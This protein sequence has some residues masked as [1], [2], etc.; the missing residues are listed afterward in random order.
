MRDVM[1]VCC[2]KCRAVM[3]G[4]SLPQIMRCTTCGFWTCFGRRR[5]SFSSKHTNYDLLQKQKQKC[6]KRREEWIN[7][8]KHDGWLET[9]STFN[10]QES[11]WAKRMKWKK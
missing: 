4:V 10:R 1:G 9:T 6:K 5:L 7:L 11:V 8:G 2:A 3:W